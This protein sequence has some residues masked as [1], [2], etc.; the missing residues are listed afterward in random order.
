MV[1][2][3]RYILMAIYSVVCLAIIV[4]VMKQNKEDNGASGTIM[5]ASANNFYE[6]NKG[7]TNE[8]KMKI[9]T[10]ILMIVFVVLT[11]TLGILYVV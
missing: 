11:L 3:I 6:K 5:G 4:L 10:I 9:A 1:N 2:V 7:K 8:G